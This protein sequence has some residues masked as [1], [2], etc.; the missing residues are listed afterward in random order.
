MERRYIDREQLAALLRSPEREHVLVIDVRGEDFVGGNI[1]GAVNVGE[2]LACAA[3][4][5]VKGQLQ[6]S[7]PALRVPGWA[8][9][10]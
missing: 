3:Q 8:V 1:K 10:C 9:R 2:G 6:P 4:Q 5:H 7:C